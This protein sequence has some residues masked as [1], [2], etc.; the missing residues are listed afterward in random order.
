MRKGEQVAKWTAQRDARARDE[1]AD[2]K[3]SG[4]DEGDAE[5]EG[6]NVKSNERP[7]HT[8]TP[9]EGGNFGQNR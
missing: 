9:Q 3:K 5:K 6:D 4:N 7:K 8:T 1:S 2:V